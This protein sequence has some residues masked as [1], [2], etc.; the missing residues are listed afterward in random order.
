[1]YYKNMSLHAQNIYFSGLYHF[2]G[3]NSAYSSKKDNAKNNVSTLLC[4]LVLFCDTMFELCF[5]FRYCWHWFASFSVEAN[6]L[7]ILSH[8]A[9]ITQL[10]L[11]CGVIPLSYSHV[12]Y[13]NY[14]TAHTLV[15]NNSTASWNFGDEA[16]L[17]THDCLISTTAKS[18]LLMDEKDL[19][20]SIDHS[21]P[22][23][24][25]I[26]TAEGPGACTIALMKYLV[27]LHN[28]FIQSC[29][30]IAEKQPERFVLPFLLLSINHHL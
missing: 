24:Y 26:P 20:P 8:L 15:V 5:W 7:T 16:C 21:T 11:Q 13:S 14:R 30:D 18:Y 29:I 1:M 25:L 6:E 17:L 9:T 23:K 2:M 19:I 28:H 10:Y 4:F 12:Q 27:L 3:L 22:L